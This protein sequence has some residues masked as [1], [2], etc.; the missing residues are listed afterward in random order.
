MI[1]QRLNG[2]SKFGKKL[3]IRYPDIRGTKTPSEP[4]C[5]GRLPY[6]KRCSGRSSTTASKPRPRTNYFSSEMNFDPFTSKLLRN[7]ILKSKVSVRN[8]KEVIEDVLIGKDNFLKQDPKYYAK[9][10]T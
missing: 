8:G 10:N 2:K 1:F 4:S 7:L 5:G 9:Y 6:W 3:A